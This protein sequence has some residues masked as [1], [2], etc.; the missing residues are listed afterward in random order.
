M[1]GFNAPFGVVYSSSTTQRRW[2]HNQRG[3]RINTH[4][5]QNSH[6]YWCKT[7]GL[8]C[9]TPFHSILVTL[10]QSFKIFE[11]RPA[12][13]FVWGLRHSIMRAIRIPTPLFPLICLFLSIYPVNA[14]LLYLLLFCVCWLLWWKWIL[15]GLLCDLFESSLLSTVWDQTNR[16]LFRPLSLCHSYLVV[17]VCTL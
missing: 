10:L 15:G 16:T 6:I 2:Q 13:K 11:C 4:K 7:Q 14:H 17:I 5:W 12:P 3:F 8:P 9:Q 1:F